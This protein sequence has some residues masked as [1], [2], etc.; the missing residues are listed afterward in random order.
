MVPSRA[1][2]RRD[3]DAPPRRLLRDRPRRLRCGGS[4]PWRS[5]DG[6]GARAT[7]GGAAMRELKR[8]DPA[9]RRTYVRE[10]TPDHLGRR[11]VTVRCFC[12]REDR[13][14]LA[15]WRQYEREAGSA[16]GCSSKACRA[17][18]IADRETVALGTGPSPGDRN[19]H[20]RGAGA[21]PAHDL[22]RCRAPCPATPTQ[23]ARPRSRVRATP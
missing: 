21:P 17:K 22:A 2:A 15:M 5:R 14:P 3:A 18:W 8:G 7:R 19:G 1:G 12:G 9:G 20:R 6:A 4:S 23:R 11:H 13:V 10:T 16:W